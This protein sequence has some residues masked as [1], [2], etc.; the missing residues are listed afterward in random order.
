MKRLLCSILL[1]GPCCIQLSKA[2]VHIPASFAN[3]SEKEWADRW[4]F[5]GRTEEFGYYWWGT[6][7]EQVRDKVVAEPGWDVFA[8]DEDFDAF[9]GLST[10]NSR[11]NV[12][13]MFYFTKNKAGAPGSLFKRRY[14][15]PPDSRL[16]EEWTERLEKLPYNNE[17]HIWT[18]A[19]H[20]AII[21][22]GLDSK[23]QVVFEVVV[24]SEK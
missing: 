19:L 18:D 15:Y 5:Y 7:Y 2:Q 6:T 20:Y 24:Y 14:V 21:T 22:R 10:R 9:N 23:S 1:L 16:L 8:L 11:L 12:L 17:K 4:R 3:P 13:M